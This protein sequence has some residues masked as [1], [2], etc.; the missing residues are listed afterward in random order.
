MTGNQQAVDFSKSREKLG[1]SDWDSSEV[2]CPVC[3]WSFGDLYEHEDADELECEEC[4][5]VLILSVD[6]SVDYKLTAYKR[7]EAELEALAEESLRMA[8]RYEQISVESR[9]RAA[10]EKKRVDA[11]NLPE[12]WSDYDW[13]GWVPE[14]VRNEIERFHSR[15]QGWGYGQAR[16]YNYAL[17][18][19]SHHVLCGDSCHE[20]EGRYIHC[21]NNMGR[22]VT[23][24]GEVF[25][26][27]CGPKGLRY[28]ST[29]SCPQRATAVPSTYLQIPGMQLPNI[30]Y[31]P[32]VDNAAREFEARGFE[33]KVVL[34]TGILLGLA[35][36]AV[37]AALSTSPSVAELGG[38]VAAGSLFGSLFAAWCLSLLG[39]ALE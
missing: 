4:D 33:S 34:A 21:W 15:P 10:E 17:P 6:H 39:G 9:V 20:F 11:L 29:S 36:A 13:P 7:S 1:E 28:R 3:G 32:G 31:R 12:R 16:A 25:V 2:S 5:A 19:G 30:E 18:M 35:A 24:R 8:A 37:Y 26:V 14:S 22:I 27:S 23:E 38:V